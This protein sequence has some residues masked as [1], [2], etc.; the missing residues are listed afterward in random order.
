MNYSV[1]FYVAYEKF[2]REREKEIL[3]YFRNLN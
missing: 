1:V 2:L 3:Q